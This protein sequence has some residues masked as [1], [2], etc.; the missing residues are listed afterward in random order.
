MLQHQ[1][2]LHASRLV[3][4]ESLSRNDHIGDFVTRTTITSVQ[5]C[6]AHFAGGAAHDSDSGTG[7]FDHSYYGA[8]V[9]DG[10]GWRKAPSGDA[11][12]A[13]APAVVVGAV[14]PAASAGDE[15]DDYGGE[16]LGGFIVIRGSSS[17][18][19][20][21]ESAMLVREARRRAGIVTG[22]SG[23]NRRANVADANDDALS[24]P[25]SSPPRDRHRTTSASPPR[26][27]AHKR[28]RSLASPAQQTPLGAASAYTTATLSLAAAARTTAA[29]DTRRRGDVEARATR[30]VPS[31]SKHALSSRGATRAAKV[32]GQSKRAFSSRSRRRTRSSS[33]SS[34]DDDHSASSSSDSD[35][36][37]TKQARQSRRALKTSRANDRRGRRRQ[38]R[39]TSRASS[40]SSVASSSTTASPS[41]AKRYVPLSPSAL[42][43][44]RPPA[45]G[46][47]LAGRG[48]GDAAIS[49]NSKRRV[50][51]A[52]GYDDGDGFVVADDEDE[53]AED[54]SSASADNFDDE[55]GDNDEESDASGRRRRV[56]RHRKK[57]R[58][59]RDD[60]DDDEEEE[61]EEEED[62]NDDDDDD[63]DMQRRPRLR[64]QLLTQQR[65]RR[66]HTSTREAFSHAAFD[67]A[68]RKEVEK[69]EADGGLGI[70]ATTVLS[71]LPWGGMRGT[72]R[73]T[74]YMAAAAPG[75]AAAA[76][77]ATT[78]FKLPRDSAFDIYLRF[79]VAGLVLPDGGRSVLQG[80]V[81]CPDAKLFHR[82]VETIERPL[83]A[84]K[85][86][87]VSSTA[88]TDDV[89]VALEVLPYYESRGVANSNEADCE[90]CRRTGHPASFEVTMSGPAVDSAG[91]NLGAGRPLTSSFARGKFWTD[92]LPRRDHAYYSTTVLAGRF[93]RQRAEAYSA[94]NHAK[95]RLLCALSAWLN[96]YLQRL[97][98]ASELGQSLLLP[99]VV[100]GHA[101][102]NGSSSDIT[103]VVDIDSDDDG[104]ES[105][106]D[107]WK[108]R[109]SQ[110]AAAQRAADESAYLDEDGGGASDENGDVT[111]RSMSEPSSNESN[112]TTA[113]GRVQGRQA[114]HLERQPVAE[115][116]RALMP[117]RSAFLRGHARFLRSLR[118]SEERRR[119]S[120]PR[121]K[122]RTADEVPMP[123][124][125][126]ASPPW[127][128]VLPLFECEAWSSFVAAELSSYESL[129]SYA[130]GV[131]ATGDSRGARRDEMDTI[132]DGVPFLTGSH[133]PKASATGGVR[134][135]LLYF[136]EHAPM[137]NGTDASRGNSRFAMRARGTQRRENKAAQAEAVSASVPSYRTT[138]HETAPQPVSERR[139]PTAQSDDSD[140]AASLRIADLRRQILASAAGGT[141]GMSSL[142]ALQG[143]AVPRRVQ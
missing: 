130:N 74:A 51:A 142:E 24:V 12:V 14:A 131:Y 60:D 139:S 89:R 121:V 102:G 137:C 15:G 122:R 56:S 28:L 27:A 36:V 37:A 39:M 109:E 71:G 81:G 124:R 125:L 112:S 66:R 73:G 70:A 96:R 75:R 106:T 18:G 91:L 53:E 103:A 1:R 44:S 93:C 99:A 41:R 31:R 48:D 110:A 21:S 100:V 98:P 136:L 63:D 77:S 49:S 117:A 69:Q 9:A 138:A 43:P 68:Q 133:V 16:S 57:R 129:L 23:I 127:E 46:R 7:D 35:A 101:R 26:S 20:S 94:L 38:R 76:I 61:E 140:A 8:P 47:Y 128:V 55:R 42:S 78:S 123:E 5:H 13:A 40:S 126:P 45:P 34:L 17:S 30:T 67:A 119:R 11:L 82:V 118:E 114:P 19:S 87:L 107:V 105:S 113:E 104:Q 86:A 25:S 6:G 62:E 83:L 134:G 10:R 72:S 132:A 120:S 29:A 111:P 97:R 33:N 2:N 116:W 22:A 143:G 3:T 90:I 59:D 32:R 135:A 84:A 141:P 64:T 52:A 65:R 95:Y 54:G 115:F 108:P 92:A 58:R 4:A 79:L 88:W 80:K 50:M 85:D